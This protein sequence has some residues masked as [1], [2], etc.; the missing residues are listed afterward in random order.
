VTPG[1]IKVNVGTPMNILPHLSDDF[2]RSIEDFRK[3]LEDRVK[4]LFLELIRD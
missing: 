4:A 3:A 1:T 2:S